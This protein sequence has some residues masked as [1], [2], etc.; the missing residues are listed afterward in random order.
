MFVR[1]FRLAENF[2]PVVALHQEEGFSPERQKYLATYVQL[3]D[4][5][6]VEFLRELHA[7][8]FW[9]PSISHKEVNVANLHS[10]LADMWHIL[11]A[12]T[13]L[14]GVGPQA[15]FKIFCDKN[16]IN[17]QRVKDKS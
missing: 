6:S 12:I 11:I 9:R 7:R 13:I 8:K 5:E 3:L 1:Q 14:S 10:E 2:I 16:D 15:M 17:L 4:E